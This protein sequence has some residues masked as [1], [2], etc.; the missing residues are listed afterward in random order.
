MSSQEAR[1]GGIHHITAIAGDPQENL[2]FYAGV[3]GLRLVKRSVNQD[4]PTT[5]HLFYADKEAHPGTDL[6]FFPWP[7]GAP[8]VNGTGLANEV[9]LAIAPGSLPYWRDRLAEHGVKARDGPHHFGEPTLRFHDPH[10]LRLALVESPRAAERA[11]TPWE[12][13]EVP[14][15]HQVRGLHAAR[16]VVARLEPT[17]A[18]AQG[19]LGMTHVGSD[20]GWERYEGRDAWSGYLDVRAEP[21]TPRGHWGVGTV[22][23]VAWRMRDDD[24]QLAVRAAVAAQRINPTPVIDRFWFHSVYFREPGGVLFELATD[25]PGF[26]VDEPLEALGDRLVLPPWLEPQR[27]AIEDALPPLEVPRKRPARTVDA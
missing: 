5:Y 16:L 8:G 7:H 25:G 2:S 10:A 11:F 1:V 18:F 3:L 12:G 13:S 26:T 27:E 19:P 20:D 22:H 21:A 4:D 24:E 14:A 23:H 15:E 17:A 6:T 9:A